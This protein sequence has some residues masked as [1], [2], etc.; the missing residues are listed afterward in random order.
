MAGY[1]ISEDDD[2]V[3]SRIWSSQLALFFE[4]KGDTR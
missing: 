1:A 3:E 4:V 2:Y